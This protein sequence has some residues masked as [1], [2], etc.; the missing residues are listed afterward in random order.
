MTA[1]LALESSPQLLQHAE[2]PVNW[3]LWGEQALSPARTEGKPIFPS[4]GYASCHWWHVMAH[5]SFEDR[6][7]T[8]LLNEHVVSMKVEREDRPQ[9]DGIFMSALQ[10]VTGHGGWPMSMFLMP[11]GSHYPLKARHGHP[12]CP[13]VSQTVVEAWKSRRQDIDETGQQIVAALNERQRRLAKRPSAGLSREALGKARTNLIPRR[14]PANGG[15]D[16]AS[17]RYAT[18][19]RSSSDGTWRPAMEQRNCFRWLGIASL[20]QGVRRRHT[21]RQPLRGGSGCPTPED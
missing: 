3:Y 11:D 10:A 19:S 20:F 7:L 21:A 8:A 16:T 18:C 2:K 17:F 1:R 5:E 4:V 9:I 13:D 6:V 15:R 12:A 14:D